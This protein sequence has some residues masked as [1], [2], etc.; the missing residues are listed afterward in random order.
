M[1]TSQDLFDDAVADEPEDPPI[2]GTSM[3]ASEERHRPRAVLLH[4]HDQASTH[5]LRIRK[6]DDTLAPVPIG[7]AIPRR[8]FPDA[9]SQRLMLIFFKPWCHASDLRI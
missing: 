3:M 8:E 7:P 4:G 1:E 9:I 5:I 6:P 2:D